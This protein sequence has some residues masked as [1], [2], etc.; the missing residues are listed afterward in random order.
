MVKTKDVNKCSNIRIPFEYS[1]TV[2]EFE[3]SHFLYVPVPL[4]S[5]KKKNYRPT[6]KGG[7]LKR[8]ISVVNC[9][10]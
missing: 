7:L 4:L 10:M 3:Y 9:M 5:F 8:I 1:N 2:S 6:L